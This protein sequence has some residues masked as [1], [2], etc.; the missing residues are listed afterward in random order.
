MI[1]LL[2]TPVLLNLEAGDDSTHAACEKLRAGNHSAR[3]LPVCSHELIDLAIT[4]KNTD[5]IQ[6]LQKARAYGL[7]RVELNGVELDLAKTLADKLLEAGV[8]LN[9][10][11]SHLVAEACVFKQSAGQEVFIVSTAPI[12]NRLHGAKIGA[13][14]DSQGLPAIRFVSIEKL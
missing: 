5:G 8:V 4:R 1:A 13:V 3:F 12:I 2:D 10:T 11:T 9:D 6:F 7:L 14:A